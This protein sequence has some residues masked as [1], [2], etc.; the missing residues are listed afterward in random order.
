LRPDQRD[1][2][3]LPP[4]DVLDPILAQ[5]IEGN[6]SKRQLLDQGFEEAVIDEVQRRI[7]LSE[8]KRKQ[9]PPGIKISPKAFGSGRRIP[10]TNGYPE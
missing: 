7:R 1:E 5:L 8:H 9:L 4:Y 10:L 3:D 6:A 2:D